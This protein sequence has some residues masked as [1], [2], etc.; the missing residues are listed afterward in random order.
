MTRRICD[1]DCYMYILS[2]G[3]QQGNQHVHWHLAPLPPGVP[4]HLQQLAAL[5][6]DRSIL[7]LSGD[8][9]AALAERGKPCRRMMLAI[10]RPTC[11]T[12]ILSSWP[13]A[14]CGTARV[15]P[16]RMGLPSMSARAE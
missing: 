1:Q 8:E 2:L 15:C 10:L 16:C 13:A 9:R 4:Y 11:P 7:D 3:R 12:Q 6:F 14:E 5:S